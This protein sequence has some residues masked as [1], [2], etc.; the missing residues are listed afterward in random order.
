MESNNIYY[1]IIHLLDEC[2]N[3]LPNDELEEM[4]SLVNSNERGVA[5]ENLCTQL[6]EYSVVLTPSQMNAITSI[7]VSLGIDSSYWKVLKSNQ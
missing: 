6:H 5:V 3:L 7:C 1:Q 4:R 2:V